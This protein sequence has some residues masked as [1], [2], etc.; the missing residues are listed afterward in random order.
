MSDD[1]KTVGARRR[2]ASDE[3][4][5]H[6][7]GKAVRG[8]D[9]HATGKADRT[10]A[11]ATGRASRRAAPVGAEGNLRP[12]EKKDDKGI[13]QHLSQDIQATEGQGWPATFVLDGTAY[14]NEGVLSDSSGE[15][16]IFT[17]SHGGKRYVLKL[18]YYDP[19]HRPN[20]AILEKIHQ[21]SGSGLLVNIISHGEW[22]NPLRPGEKNDYELMDFCEGGSLDGVVLAGDEKTLAQVAVRMASAI[23][24]LA[25]HGILHRDIKPANFF[26]ADKART[27]IVL[28]DFGISVECPQGGVCK[29]DEMRS[30][31][32][33]APEFYTNVPGEPAEVGVESDYFSLGVSLLCLWMGKAKLTA[34]ESQLLR[35][36]LNE[37]LP[38]PEDLSP[39][40]ASLIRALTRLKMS[41][42][43]TFD[44]IRRWAK[45][46]NLD[47]GDRPEVSVDFHIVFNAAKNL[48]AHSPSELARLLLEDKVLGKKYLY[49]GRITRWLEETGRNEVAVN[50]EEIVEKV[51]PSNQEAGLMAVA[52]MLDPS[53]DYVDP[54]GGHHTDPQEISL[55]IFQHHARMAEEVLRPDSNLM[56]YLHAL[57]MDKTIAAVREYI[58]SEQFDTG[59][60]EINGFIACYYLA[61]LLNPD[62]IFPVYTSKGWVNAET[63]ADLLAAYRREGTL[64]ASNYHLLRSKAL[65]VWLASRNPALAGKIRLLHDNVSDD[66]E[67]IYFNATS[68]YRIAYELDPQADLG[69]DTDPRAKGRCYTIEQ[70]GEYLNSRLNAMVLG[71]AETGALVVEFGDMDRTPVGDYLRARG[72]AY[73]RFLE[74]NRYCMDT[75]NEEN[76]QKAGPYDT[77]IGAYKSVAGFLGH[78][79]VYPL[80]GRLLA[81]LQDVDKLPRETV[82][83]AFGEKVRWMNSQG[84]VVPWLDAWLAVSFQENPRLDLSP[85]F[86]Y[87]R[88]TARYVEFLEK[89]APKN[90]YVARYATAIRQIDQAAGKLH[91]SEKQV[92]TKRNVFL[93][94]GILPTVMVLL[95]AWLFGL[96]EVNPIKGH[97]WAATG[98]CFVGL[99]VFQTR[100]WGFW[101]GLIPAAVGG[102]VCAGLLYVGFRWFPGVLAFCVAALLLLAAFVSIYYL[103]K[104]EK[105]DTEGKVIRGDE[106]EYRQLDALYYAYRQ[107]DDVLDNVV[108]KYSQMQQSYDK[109]NRDNLSFVGWQWISI[110]WM[111]FALWYLI[112]PQVSG[113][114]SWTAEAEAIQAQKGQWVLG[115]WEAKY[116]SGSTRIVCHIDS[117]ADGKHIFG[118]MVIAGQAPVEAKGQVYSRQDT[119]PKSFTFYPVEHELGKQMLRAE[120]DKREYRMEGY[121]DDRRGIQH[122]VVFLATPLK[123]VSDKADKKATQSVGRKEPAKAEKPAA[124]QVENNDTPKNG[125]TLEE[126]ES[127]VSGLWQDTM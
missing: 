57:K 44:D 117:V 113:S 69:F 109:T 107:E 59:E 33:A 112:T 123:A 127:P 111:I 97:F 32:Y 45:G 31:V 10:D 35:S 19:E 6:A 48:V 115:K 77:I 84:R 65:I 29:I 18:Y 92:T 66:V 12:F 46:D 28:A 72:E 114:R 27:Q 108:T 34:N 4:D 98:I 55:A 81:S 47:A 30:P 101:N 70:V 40:M 52:Y 23:D 95:G 116:E 54:M 7:T 8:G 76:R 121:Y 124:E 100:L 64:H 63:V 24:F 50:V 125:D 20:H 106:F 120:Y 22:Q 1:H 25:R 104:R 9:V 89:Y 119:L 41:D 68:A 103:F 93:V 96:P 39:H 26:Y 61:V 67:S 88:E 83:Q 21:L 86:T 60:K 42:R 85:Q 13:R 5:V 78:A 82:A 58:D 90:Y 3:A 80:E 118:T 37:T 110:A 14:Q 36:K 51:Y 126:E 53:M 49:S 2:P 79:P 74:W 11:H 99:L 91:K 73:A 38:M 94:L 71:E 87:E 56:V 122:S 43:A 102:V 75:E 105:V 17:V 15:A 16:I 62:M